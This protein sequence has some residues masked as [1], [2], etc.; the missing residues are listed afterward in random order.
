MWKSQLGAFVIT[1]LQTI[2][3]WTREVVLE[4]QRNRQDILKAELAIS[5]GL[6]MRS[7]K[8]RKVLNNSKVK[9]S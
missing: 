1:Q 8:G 9:I 2:F 5:V 3:F 4:V 6:D 7:Q